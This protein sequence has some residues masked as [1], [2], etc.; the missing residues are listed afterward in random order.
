M[1][2]F[3]NDNNTYISTQET[4]KGGIN[5]K[6]RRTGGIYGPA[7]IA[8]VDGSYIDEEYM[9]MQIGN[10][11][12]KMYDM[13]TTQSNK[14]SIRTIARRQMP[15]EVYYNLLNFIP[16]LNSI[17][18]WIKE[19]W[20]DNYYLYL[21]SV[22]RHRINGY[23]NSF[24]GYGKAADFTVRKKNGTMDGIEFVEKNDIL[25]DYLR[26]KFPDRNMITE[27]LKEGT[28]GE[29]TTN[30]K[31]WIHLSILG[32]DYPNKP[33]VCSA[34]GNSGSCIDGKRYAIT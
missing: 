26:T 5:E 18:K 27:L 31:G 9:D 33:I 6:Y 11:K 25:Y 17:D 12:Y 32:W 8:I 14:G 23:F 7:P 34:I 2:N 21:H 20:G 10:T 29:F 1:K 30:H 28:N 24:H 16:Y 15:E 4:Y 22:W 3:H 13:I 19:T